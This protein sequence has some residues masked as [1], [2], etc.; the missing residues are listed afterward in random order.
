MV[1]GL[2]AVTVSDLRSSHFG[3]ENP[4][5]FRPRA[6]CSEGIVVCIIFSAVSYENSKIGLVRRITS[7][8]FG[9]LKWVGLWEVRLPRLRTISLFGSSSTSL[10]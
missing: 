6:W 9:N 5:A 8:F 4:F 10:C 3:L 1:L 2:S 7:L